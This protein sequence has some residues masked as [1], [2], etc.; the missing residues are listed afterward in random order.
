MHVSLCVCM[1]VSVH[2]PLSVCML[3]ILARLA[4]INQVIQLAMNNNNNNT[5]YTAN[6]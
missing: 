6:F 4:K 2:V 1:S 3:L 5:V